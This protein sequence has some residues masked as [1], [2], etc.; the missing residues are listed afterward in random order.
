MSLQKPPSIEL[1]RHLLAAGHEELR[2][3]VRMRDEM[4]RMLTTAEVV[5]AYNECLIDPETY[6]WTDGMHDWQ[7]LQLVDELVD[8]LHAEA[9]REAKA[10]SKRTEESAMFSLASLVARPQESVAARDDDSGLIDL[11]A[12]SAPLSQAQPQVLPFDGGLFPVPVSAPRPT[13]SI[14]PAADH[15][16]VILGLMAAVGVLS[17]LLVFQI[18]RSGESTAPPAEEIATTTTAAPPAAPPEIAPRIEPSSPPVESAPELAKS[19]PP[20]IRRPPVPPT[21]SASVKP[22][23]PPPPK[24]ICRCKP[25]D[26]DCYMRC[27]VN[28]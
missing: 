7:Q 12:L 3:H 22:P 1:R 9:D 19:A 11:A 10:P 17:A 28:K 16:G 8:A 24:D 27:A 6:V 4:E 15:R 2:W 13:V 14:K 21:T 20:V 18:V 26:L 5:D 23:P 25:E